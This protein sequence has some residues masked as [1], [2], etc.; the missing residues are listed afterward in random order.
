MSFSRRFI[1]VCGFC[2]IESAADSLPSNWC[3]ITDEFFQVDAESQSGYNLIRAHMCF[4]GVLVRAR[5]PF[6]ADLLVGRDVVHAG[7]W[8]MGA[9]EGAND[10]FVA[11][12]AR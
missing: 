12:G 9:S 1:R 5:R 10:H 11:R 3:Y 7:Q 8:N 6:Q 4:N 2:R